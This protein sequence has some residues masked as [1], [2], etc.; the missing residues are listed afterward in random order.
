MR[1]E[2]VAVAV[3]QRERRR[4]APAEVIGRLVRWRVDRE[5]RHGSESRRDGPGHQPCGVGRTCPVA[6]TCR[7][8]T[9]LAGDT[10]PCPRL[11]TRRE[12]SEQP[13]AKKVRS[14]AAF[15][16]ERPWTSFVPESVLKFEGG[17]RL[18]VIRGKLAR[19]AGAE[20]EDA[21]LTLEQ[22]PACA[23]A[24]AMLARLP[25]FALSLTNHSGAEYSFYDATGSADGA[26][27][28]AEVIWPASARQIERKTP[29]ASALV[30][31]S[32]RRTRRS[33]RRTRALAARLGGGSPVVAATERERNLHADAA[34]RQRRPAGDARPCLRR[35]RRRRGRARGPARRAVDAGPVPARDL[36][37]ATLASLRDLRGEAGAA[38]CDRMRDA[39]RDCAE[40]VYGV[41]RDQ[42]RVFFHYHPQFYR[43]HA[44]C[45]RIEYVNPGCEA[46]RAHLLTSVADNLRRDAGFYEKATLTYK[47]RVG[48][49]LHTLLQ[50]H[51]LPL[52]R[53]YRRSIL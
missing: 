52:P 53:Q 51:G 2:A 42:L 8:V 23:D 21:L 9:Q 38:L 15:T 19:A 5:V 39:L 27:Y 13:P 6:Q 11:S 18:A 44:H 17:G 24:D 34:R 40:R 30:E 35:R 14:E 25:T 36:G 49:K 31:E 32:A 28:S 3:H 22:K 20:P 37:D 1:E 47:V 10:L 43:L 33:S 4:D 41:P 45:T 7:S 48:E 26:R 29:A 16:E 12:M 46:E 50:E